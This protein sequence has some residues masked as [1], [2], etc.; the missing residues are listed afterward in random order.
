MT[1][2]P[3]GLSA[4]LRLFTRHS[5]LREFGD[6]EAEEI[7]QDVVDMSAVDCKDEEGNWEIVYMRLKFSAVLK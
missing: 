3:E 7:I 6:D 1:P 2:L 5:F 4:W